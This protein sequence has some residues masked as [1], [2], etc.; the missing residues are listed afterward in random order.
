MGKKIRNRKPQSKNN[1]LEAIM[2][3]VQDGLIVIDKNAIIQSFSP[4]AETIFGYQA[5]EVIGQNVNVLM[6]EPYQSEHDGYLK[7]FFR[8]GQKKVI[9]I[10]REVKARRKDGSIF[11]MELGVNEMVTNG[12]PMFVGTIRD[13][14]ERKEAAKRL[15]EEASRLAAVM[16]TVLDGVLTI[17]RFGTIQSYNPAA[18]RIFGYTPEE[19][20]GKNVKM[21][22][23]NPYHSEHD[24]YLANYHATGEKKVIGIGREVEAKR[25]DGSIFPMEL[26]IN[27][28]HV[29][30]Q[31]M[32]VGTIRDISE[33]KEAEKSIEKFIEK[34][35]LSN[36]ELDDFAYIASHDLKEP[37]RGLSNNALFLKEDFEDILGEAGNKRIDRITFLC[38]RMERLIDDLLYFSRLGRQDLAIQQVD[39]NLII[40]DIK[41]M[42][43]NTLE[44]NNAKI[45]VK[46][47]LPK[48]TC[49][50]PRITE[51]FRNLIT[52]A[53][54][55]NDKAEKHIEVGHYMEKDH[56]VF[57]VKDNGIGI[58]SVFFDDMFRIFKRLNDEDDNIK[59]T[60]VGLTFVKKI[61][62]RHEGKIWVES[63]PG[64]GTTFFFT[65][66][67]HSEPKDIAA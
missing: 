1:H 21:L 56:P 13:I 38:S 35:K 55:Y 23:P 50:V 67:T 22:M 43:L 66:Y 34:L 14:T 59:G 12:K 16:N 54:K 36:Q 44:D 11:P 7:N 3:T 20:M 27:E 48:I 45:I 39:V 4:A 29:Q 15:T 62:D 63:E 10:G 2:N 51:A 28:M 17:D 40:E 26:G 24:G 30:D 5:H 53:I 57:Y 9:G 49:D 41:A 18:E 32:F 64:Q 8:T 61:I 58:D 60:G 42:L 31:V 46:N 25:K 19:V 33:R 37:I 65:L 52:N 47:P 6:P